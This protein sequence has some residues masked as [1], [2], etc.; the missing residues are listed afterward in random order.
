MVAGGY[1]ESVEFQKPAA[2]RLR[3]LLVGTATGAAAIGGSVGYA[4]GGVGEAILSSLLVGAA[5]GG[6]FLLSSRLID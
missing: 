4:L 1:G 6:G 2:G 3:W 5:A